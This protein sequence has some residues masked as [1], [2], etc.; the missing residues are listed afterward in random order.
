MLRNFG[1]QDGELYKPDSMEMGGGN[2]SGN[3]APSGSDKGGFAGMTPPS[4]FSRG[5]AGKGETSDADNGRPSFGGFSDGSFDP[6]NMPEGFDPG[7]MPGSG[8]KS[9][10]MPEGF[11]PGNMPDGGNFNF[12]PDNMPGDLNPDNMPS[13]SFNPGSMPDGG[14]GQADAASGTGDPNRSGRGGMSGKGGANLNYSDDELDSYSTIWEGEIT[15]TDK[16]DHRRVVT[17][18]KNICEGTDLETYLNVDNVLRYMAVHVF[19]VN[20]DSLSGSMAHNYYLYEYDGQLDLFPWDYNLSFGGMSMGSSGSGT[21]MVNDAID[22]PFSG[23]QFFDV[24]LEDETYLAQYHSYLQQLVDEYVGSG[25][26]EETYNR[27]RGQIDELV[28]TD[29]TAFYSYDE[30]ETAAHM[31]YDTVMLRAESIRGQLDGSIPSTDNG[32]REDTSALIDASEIDVKVMGQ[33]SMGGFGG[34]RDKTVAESS[35]EESEASVPDAR[36]NTG[37]PPDMQSADATDETASTASDP[38]TQ[39]ESISE[40]A[41]SASIH[42]QRPPFAGMSEQASGQAKSRNLIIFG[43]CFV[44]MLI[45]LILVKLYKRNRV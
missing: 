6:A 14:S 30:Y 37:T 21:D 23:T 36:P 10:N 29:P 22:T 35:A 2:G 43:A 16:V 28:K 44:V 27:I 11:D 18:L 41:L 9:G 31:L 39:E 38:S 8:F 12:D 19:S 13:G 45:A 17:A 26:F 32:Q 25:R 34:Q 7:S 20:M 42:R 1:T 3:S 4:G 24:L 5:S 15:G 40:T 33:F